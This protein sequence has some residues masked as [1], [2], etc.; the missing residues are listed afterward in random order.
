M[1]NKRIK[2]LTQ[3]ATTLANDDYV[4]I[5]GSSNGT[6][7]IVKSDLVNDISS[8]VAGTY[9]DEANNLSDVASL[10]TSKLNLEV[11]DVGTAPNEVPLNSHLGSMAYQDSAA[12][13]VGE[14]AADS[15]TT[16]TGTAQ[17]L[18]VSDVN[19]DTDAILTTKSV[20][21]GATTL[22]LVARANGQVEVNKDLSLVG[23]EKSLTFH[24]DEGGM[25]LSRAL[26]KA[27]GDPSGAGFGGSLVIHTSDDGTF[28]ERMR[29]DPQ[30]R[31]GIGTDSP[32]SYNGSADDLVVGDESGD[33][34]MT[35]VSGAGSNSTI[36]FADGT[37]AAAYVGRVQYNHLYNE[38][39]LGTAGGV[40]WTINS[41]GNLVAG[42]NLGID[43]GSGASGSG[44]PITNGGLLND[45]ESG[46]FTPTDGS[47]AGLSFT[48]AAGTYIK[49][50]GQVTCWV[51]LNYPTNSD[52]TPAAIQGL[53]FPFGGNNV[54]RVGGPVVYNN[55][56]AYLSVLGVTSNSKVQI[57][58][59]T[60]SGPTNA[61]LSAQSI[62]F[63]VTYNVS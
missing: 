15:I 55:F 9:L 59:T 58:R 45:Y 44:T 46:T 49:V 54:D 22:G 20:V 34:G 28:A 31:V 51:V 41:T 39:R 56:G 17:N 23:N 8:Q 24:S 11:P 1:A 6:R 63:C 10:D 57:F 4:A 48:G 47:G 14:V 40:R 35:I 36:Y 62:W 2:D 32:S 29:V 16:T 60:G 42:A 50:G 5:D 12:I 21:S 13:S 53:P 18:T 3:T 25:N 33:R 52:A 27:D 19:Y 7:K 38:L 30:G 61:Q 43:F 26:I 37:G